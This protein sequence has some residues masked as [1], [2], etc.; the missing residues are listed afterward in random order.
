MGMG[1]SAWLALGVAGQGRNYT[2]ALPCSLL[3]PAGEAGHPAARGLSSAMGVGVSLLLQFSLTS[4]DYQSVGRSQSY[5]HQSIPRT[6]PKRNWTRPCLRP[7]RLQG[8]MGPF[9]GSPSIRHL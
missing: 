2:H 9:A 1:V 4:G 5:S 8:T 3:S 6:D 7:Y